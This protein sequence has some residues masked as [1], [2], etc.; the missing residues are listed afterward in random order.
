[1]IKEERIMIQDKWGRLWE[2]R[3]STLFLEQDAP[4]G[5]VKAEGVGETPPRLSEKSRRL[6]DEE[7]L[8]MQRMEAEG[9]RLAKEGALNYTW[10]DERKPIEQPWQDPSIA[11]YDP[12]HPDR[13][14]L[15]YRTARRAA[16]V[17]TEQRT[18]AHRER[19]TEIVR[20]LRTGQYTFQQVADKYKLTREAVRVISKKHLTP[21]EH[22]AV[23]MLGTQ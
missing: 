7:K 17:E 15:D 11:R 18:L 23:A 12:F 1:M 3:G 21:D 8:E 9:R 6:N 20:E 14:T 19:T 5:F 22:N 13:S 16:A 4:P 10:T 2:W